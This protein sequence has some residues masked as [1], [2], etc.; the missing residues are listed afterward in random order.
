MVTKKDPPAKVVP[1]NKKAPSKSLSKRRLMTMKQVMPRWK[2][3]SRRWWYLISWFPPRCAVSSSMRCHDY[4][5]RRRRPTWIGHRFA[6]PRRSFYSFSL[7][8][9]LLSFLFPLLTYPK[10]SL[11][12]SRPSTRVTKQAYFEGISLLY[13]LV[14][15]SLLLLSSY[16]HQLLVSARKGTQ[17]GDS[18]E[19]QR[20]PHWHLRVDV[21]V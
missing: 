7:F 14:L 1:P 11:K 3:K 18:A 15:Y 6:L 4:G 20:R 10:P 19:Q 2:L 5:V 16:A 12:G 9:C 8:R 17:H 21:G 13:S